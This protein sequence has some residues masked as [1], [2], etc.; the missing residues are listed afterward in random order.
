MRAK[1]NKIM[2]PSMM[3]RRAALWLALVSLTIAT[4]AAFAQT[5]FPSK[6]I[7]LL[8]PFAPGGGVDVVA[9]VVGK[10]VSDMTGQPVL[11]ESKPGGGGAIAVAE[12][13]RSD[14]D[15]Y[16]LLMTTSAHATLPKLN[17]LPWHPSNDFSPIASIYSYMFVIATNA[18]S[19]S[20]FATF[21]AFLK[22]VR[23][24]PGKINWG[25]SGIGGPQHLGGSQFVK[26]AGLDMVHVPYRG[27]GPMGQALL[28]DDVQIVFDTP[29][30]LLPRI[31]DGTLI[32]LAVTG[33]KRLAA[34]PNIPTVRETGLV[35]FMYRGQIFVLGP[36]GMPAA[37]QALLNAEF[38]SALEDKEVRAQLTGFGLE[39]PDRAENT[40]AALKQHIDDF[41]AT[42]DKLIDELK[43]EPQ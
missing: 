33:D 43:I 37:V 2:T 34:L 17:R 10:K 28:A 12:L 39:V 15:G 16:T 1:R 38:A 36:K 13:M 29:T 25:S 30:L 14:P 26:V 41:K 32:A 27:N 19:K 9:R 4:P 6:P 3:T 11:V 7:R 35:D 40:V 22:Y 24:N 5:R 18:Q 23:A 21:D 8:V 31:Q 20:R 42:Y